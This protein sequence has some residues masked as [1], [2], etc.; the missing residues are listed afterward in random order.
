MAAATRK[1]AVALEK[2][3]HARDAEFQKALHGNSAQ[4]QGG[5]M[6]MFRKDGSAKQAA[7]DEY[8]KHWDNKDAAD[9]T[10]NDREVSSRSALC[11]EI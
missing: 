1:G 2:E 8:F 11:S 7:V 6:A 3:D 5:L 4:V 10:T 9:E